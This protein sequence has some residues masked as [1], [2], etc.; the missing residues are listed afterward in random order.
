MTEIQIQNGCWQRPETKFINEKD[1]KTA[2]TVLQWNILKARKGWRGWERD[3][4]KS[5]N[6]CYLLVQS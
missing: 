5:T 1:L 4:G 2:K 3:K 6:H